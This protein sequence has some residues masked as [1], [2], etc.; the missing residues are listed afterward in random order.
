MDGI[1]VNIGR[2]K[3]LAIHG[4]YTL[5]YSYGFTI[6]MRYDDEDNNMDCLRYR[7]LCMTT[8]ATV[9][10]MMNKHRE[11]QRDLIILICQHHMN[12]TEYVY[13]AFISKLFRK[14]A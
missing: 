11:T 1:C 10:M 13:I 2:Y 5:L 8:L 14:K 12:V 4:H 9:I 3:G 6:Y 7:I